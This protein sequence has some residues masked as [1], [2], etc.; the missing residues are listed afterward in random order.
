MQVDA[1]QAVQIYQELKFW[2]PLVTAAGFLWKIFQGVAWLRG[3]KTDLMD[4]KIQLAS[5]TA[6][7]QGQ[8]TL[9]T[10]A[11]V[12]ELREIRQDF[13]TAMQPPPRLARARS[14]KKVVASSST[15]SL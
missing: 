7:L 8:L 14:S 6:T 3:F 1:S 13:R 9:N 12:S 11:I 5:Q 10:T 2:L 15:D 4:M